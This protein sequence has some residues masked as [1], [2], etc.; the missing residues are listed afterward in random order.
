MLEYVRRAGLGRVRKFPLTHCF[1]WWAREGSNLQPD[2]YGPSGRNGSVVTQIDTQA[3]PRGEAK[4][5]NLL[6]GLV[7]E[8]GLEPPTRGL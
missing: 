5:P 7:A 8:E 1:C 3:L 2:G 4:L 6:I